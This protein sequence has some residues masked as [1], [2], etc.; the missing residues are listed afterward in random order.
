MYLR[1][2]RMQ[3]PNDRIDRERVLEEFDYFCI[4]I[5]E[6]FPQADFLTKQI[7]NTQTLTADSWVLCLTV[8]DDMILSGHRDGKKCK[9]LV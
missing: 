6:Q 5:E 2:H 1:T 4:P 7:V 8:V 9:R 3:L